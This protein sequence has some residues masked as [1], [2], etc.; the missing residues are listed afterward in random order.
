[1]TV[2]TSFSEVN[3]WFN[4]Q[5][6]DVQA[7]FVEALE[8][9]DFAD[10]FSEEE[11]GIWEKCRDMMKD[12]NRRLR[13][14]EEQEVAEYLIHEGIEDPRFIAKI[15]EI[16]RQTLEP[17]FHAKFL[18]ETSIAFF[19]ELV[20]TIINDMVVERKYRTVKRL[21]QTLSFEIT[22]RDAAGSLNTILNITN[23]FCSQL[24][25]YEDLE[26][27]MKN[28]FE[29]SEEKSAF[30]VIAIQKHKEVIERY[31]LFLNLKKLA[32]K[33]DEI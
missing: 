10:F 16:G 26:Q 25:S 33:L 19:T 2:V 5:F 30:V 18:R 15:I 23:S 8:A 6:Y 3:E 1:M 28:E 14:D 11:E 20:D 22:P 17:Y 12:V 27:I 29:F 32:R 31:S 9:N 7:A 4:N 24:L 21:L 13:S